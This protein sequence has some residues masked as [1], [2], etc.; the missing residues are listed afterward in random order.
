MTFTARQM[1]FLVLRVQDAFLD[2]PTLQITLPQAQREFGM[3]AFTCHAD[4]IAAGAP[5]H[6]LLVQSSTVVRDQIVKAPG[7]AIP[8]ASRATARPVAFS[9][10]AFDRARSVR[11]DQRP[12]CPPV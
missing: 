1:G 11:H 2:S 9:L 12:P 10:T 3:D 8:P 4:G 5:V 7:A 6:T